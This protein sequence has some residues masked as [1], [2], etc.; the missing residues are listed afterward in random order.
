MTTVRTILVVFLVVLSGVQVATTAEE[1]TRA[2]A[3][4]DRMTELGTPATERAVE[5]VNRETRGR[6]DDEILLTVEALGRVGGVEAA[7]GLVPWIQHRR[8]VVAQR[9]MEAAAAL[10]LREPTV[11]AAI[12]KALDHRKTEVAKAACRAIARVGE[13]KDIPSLIAV[14][15]TTDAALRETAY[16][17]LRNLSGTFIPDVQSR[18]TWWWKGRKG[19]AGDDVKSALLLFE[20]AEELD[21]GP[22]LDAQKQ[23]LLRAKTT[24]YRDAW[25][26]LPTIRETLKRWLLEEDPRLHVLAC[27]LIQHLRL[28]DLLKPMRYVLRYTSED[29]VSKAG[30][31]AL[32]SLGASGS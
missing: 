22:E 20:R 2:E 29:T 28:P 26:A 8:P 32:A 25:I 21:E 18:W 5:R 19:R 7:K 10:G 14:A 3:L 23:R 9:A 13:G 11:V 27:E 12:R 1:P 30:A 17:S 16:A 6:G 15:D 4:A 31:S 24:L